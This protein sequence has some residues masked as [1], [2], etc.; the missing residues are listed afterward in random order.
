[1]SAETYARE[2]LALV[3]SPE[4]RGVLARFG[5]R[6]RPTVTQ[7]VSRACERVAVSNDG[8]EQLCLVGDRMTAWRE[9]RE[10]AGIHAEVADVAINDGRVVYAGRAGGIWNWDL[11]SPPAELGLP[12]VRVARLLPSGRSRFTVQT[13]SA[14]VHVDPSKSEPALRLPCS[15]DPRKG[16][17]HPRKNGG[18]WE[19]C[20]SGRATLIL[21]DLPPI[22]YPRIAAELGVPVMAVVAADD[23]ERLVV[24]T[25]TGHLVVYHEGQILREFDAS[26]LQPSRITLRGDR[27]AA[28]RS[29]GALLV[30]DVESGAQLANLSA[31]NAEIA[32]TEVGELVVVD[33][34]GLQK[35][36]LPMP[37]DPHLMAVG[38][39]VTGV[40]VNPRASLVAAAMGDGGVRIIDPRDGTVKGSYMAASGV[41]K[42]LAFSPDGARLAAI[43]A[44]EDGI[45]MLDVGRGAELAPVPL[46]KGRRLVWLDGVMIAA[47]YAFPTKG[48]SPTGLREVWPQQFTDL[49]GDGRRAAALDNHDEIVLFDAQGGAS[50]L[51]HRPAAFAVAPVDDHVLVMEP[52]HWYELFADGSQ[53]SPVRFDVDGVELLA[54]PDGRAVV[55][56]HI[57]GTITLWRRDGRVVGRLIGHSGR[58][59][60]LVYSV[61]QR[62]LYSGSWDGT[63]RAWSMEALLESGESSDPGPAAG[64]TGI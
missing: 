17:V 41:L 61:D 25:A 47:S 27:L 13:T 5:G 2:A 31:P 21:P 30:W 46:D 8:R 54:S 40:A 34:T 7:S 43:S 59:A 1:M 60:S 53:S 62:W 9:G 51:G 38:A 29:D 58:V 20:A 45:W 26:P 15:D 64:V 16:V 63:V 44:S 48:F 19:V 22:A 49:E 56:G 57:D 36:D 14:G 6:P 18:W 3:P 35:W 33:G 32:W 10:V 24:G 11:V 55:V 52:R 28:R 50:S 42:D 39:G 4:A 37:R 23:Q 12:L